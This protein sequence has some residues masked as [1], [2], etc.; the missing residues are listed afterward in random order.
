MHLVRCFTFLLYWELS[1]QALIKLIEIYGY[2]YRIIYGRKVMEGFF[3]FFRV[4]CEMKYR[5]VCHFGVR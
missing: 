3:L 1:L 5:K 2:I 4:N